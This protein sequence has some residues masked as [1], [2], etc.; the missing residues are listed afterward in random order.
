M[1]NSNRDHQHEPPPPCAD[2]TEAGT[3]VAHDHE[4]HD[5]ESHNHDDHDHDYSDAS[6][7]SLTISLVLIGGFM[8]AEVVGGIMSGS[9]AL[10]S[11]AGHMVTDAAAIA[12]ALVA[13][14][15]A[16]RPESPERTYGYRRAEVLA[17]LLNAISLWVIAGWIF[18]EAYE[19]ITDVP[20]VEGGLLLVIGTLGLLVNIIAAWILHGS[21]E[22]SMNVE[23]AFRHVMA[24]LMGSVGVVISGVLIITLGWTIADPI[25]SVLIGVLILASS[26]RLTAKV[27]HVLMEHVPERLDVYRLCHSIE[28]IPGVTLVHDIHVWSISSGHDAFTAHILIDSEHEESVDD[29]IRRITTMVRRDYGIS[30]ATVQV[31]TSPQGCTENH[32]L[33][34]LAAFARGSRM[35]KRL[36]FI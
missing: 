15:M 23:G 25:L 29:L 11:D 21:A 16:R 9:L 6:R 22:H 12:L 28:E 33:D 19:R 18:F 26:W 7:R 34:H 24:D 35:K 27:F 2:H 8:M 17:A 14:R 13:Q 5:H 20:E 4:S 31:E 3:S 1:D 30:H 32:H 36:S 10:L